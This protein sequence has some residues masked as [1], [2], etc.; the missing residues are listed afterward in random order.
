MVR[1]IN[2]LLI[3]VA[4]VILGVAIIA[5]SCSRVSL[6]ERVAAIEIRMEE[7]R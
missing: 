3:G 7:R 5:G 4:I 6:E 2:L 1:G